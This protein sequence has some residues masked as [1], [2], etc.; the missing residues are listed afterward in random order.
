MMVLIVDSFCTQL[1]EATKIRAAAG[2]RNAEHVF[3]AGRCPVTCEQADR[4]NLSPTHCHSEGAS[5][6]MQD[7]LKA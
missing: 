1:A 5:K 3:S 7:R 2:I 6:V 4:R